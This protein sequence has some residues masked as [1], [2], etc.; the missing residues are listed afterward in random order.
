[1]TKKAKYVSEASF[2]TEIFT[3]EGETFNSD[4][5]NQLKSVS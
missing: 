2:L 3:A 1:M 5:N 4:L